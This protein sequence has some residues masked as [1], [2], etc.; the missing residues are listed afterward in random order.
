MAHL[1]AAAT[2]NLWAWFR[3]MVRARF[4]AD[5]HNRRQLEAFR[6]RTP[7][8]TLERFRQVGA[9]ELP[10]ANSPGGLGELVVHA[11]DIRR[12]LGLTH[13]YDPDGLLAVARFFATRDFAV[14]S[15]SLVGGLTVA[16][17][18]TD[19]RHGS[20]PVVQGPLLAL[21]MTMGGRSAHLGE[22]TGDGV[23]E[24]AQRL[25]RPA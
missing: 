13:T 11:E 12:P 4:D 22:L 10:L 24:L 20:G 25:G 9:I 1:G 7:K 5:L 2:T 3:S 15:K 14:N 21:V 18:D 16:A 8:D 23:P 19:F 17:T 6:G